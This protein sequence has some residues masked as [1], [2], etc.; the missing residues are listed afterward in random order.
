MSDKSVTESGPEA[1][2]AE[3][4]DDELQSRR[5][6]LI[7]LGRWSKIVIGA[8]IFGGLAAPQSDAEAGWLNRR[9]GGWVNRH[10]GWINR[11]RNGGGWVNRHG[12]GGRGGSWINRR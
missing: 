9:G 2:P 3:L 11:H 12:G 7:G 10:G 1:E 6:F 5:G 4:T 8:A